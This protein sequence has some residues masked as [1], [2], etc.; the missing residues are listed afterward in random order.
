MCILVKSGYLVE[1][2]EDVREVHDGFPVFVYL[3]EYVVSEQFD[4]VSVACLTP[5]ER[6]AEPGSMST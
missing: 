5:P 4:D 1:T 3:V 2:C 6:A